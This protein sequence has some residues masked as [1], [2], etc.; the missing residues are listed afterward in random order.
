MFKN[1]NFMM[2]L[3]FQKITDSIVSVHD[4]IN[5]FSIFINE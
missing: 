5:N 3:N 4:V 2:A 1:K